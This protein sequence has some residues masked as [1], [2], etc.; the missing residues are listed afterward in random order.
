M[1]MAYKLYHNKAIFRGVLKE[2][3]L[4]T[5][6]IVSGN[7]LRSVSQAVCAWDVCSRCVLGLKEYEDPMEPKTKVEY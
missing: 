1:K 5:H 3:I 4:F 6:N 2:N 7:C